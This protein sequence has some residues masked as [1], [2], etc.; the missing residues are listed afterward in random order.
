MRM[1]SRVGSV[2][3]RCAPRVMRLLD[4]V[5]SVGHLHAQV[6]ELTDQVR[7]LQ[8]PDNASACRCDQIA[9]QVRRLDSDLDESRALNRRAA[10]LLD[11]AVDVVAGNA[12]GR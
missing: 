8:P 3:R 5:R 1:R 7:R 4:D 11:A 6:A 10:E 2:G 9:E 12:R